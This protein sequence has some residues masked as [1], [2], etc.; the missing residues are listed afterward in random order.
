VQANLQRRGP[1]LRGTI[2]AI[3]PDGK[4]VTLEK[5]PGVDPTK[6]EI[7]LTDKTEV[8]FVGT[9]KAEEKKLTVGYY[10][11]V[12]LQEGSKDTAVVV[13]AAKPGE[14]RR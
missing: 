4:V 10:A 1:D 11:A 6:V 5:R 14:R 8:E 7:K 3:S 9:E 12:W 2:T 13:Q